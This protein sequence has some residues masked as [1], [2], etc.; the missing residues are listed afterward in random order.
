M[1]ESRW[2]PLQAGVERHQRAASTSPATCMLEHVSDADL[3]VL[4]VKQRD[5]NS[6]NTHNLP[7]QVQHGVGALWIAPQF[8][9]DVAAVCKRHKVRRLCHGSR[10]QR[11]PKQRPDTSCSGRRENRSEDCH[12]AQQAAARRRLA[13]RFCPGLWRH[14]AA[15]R[16]K[17]VHCMHKMKSNVKDDIMR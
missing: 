3:K 15:Q 4:G 17:N 9:A 16:G 13:T 1:Q 12:G 10:R 7:V 2:L 8:V 14:C 5:C 6:K 11:I